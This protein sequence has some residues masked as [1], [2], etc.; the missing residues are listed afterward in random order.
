MVSFASYVGVK[1]FLGRQLLRHLLARPMSC[2][3]VGVWGGLGRDGPA[4]GAPVFKEAGGSVDAALGVEG[5][6]SASR[7]LVIAAATLAAAASMVSA[8]RCLSWVRSISRVS[9][10]S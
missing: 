3:P 5:H 6:V 4:V 10:S 8:S 7:S 1:Q 9:V 2:R